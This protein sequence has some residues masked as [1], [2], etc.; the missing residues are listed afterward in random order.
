MWKYHTYA[1]ALWYV[2]NELLHFSFARLY[3]VSWGPDDL[4][5][6]PPMHL[7]GN[8]RGTRLRWSTADTLQIRLDPDSEWLHRTIYKDRH[9]HC[10]TPVRHSKTTKRGGDWTIKMLD[11]D[12][13]KITC[14]I[15]QL[16]VFCEQT[17]EGL[18]IPPT[19]CI[20]N[21]HYPYIHNLRENVNSISQTT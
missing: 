2:E 21:C 6:G 20:T 12:L 7:S 10:S 15:R 19:F 18:L 5:K 8:P 11:G 16:Q 13:P 9:F 3:K 17:K 4:K 1:D 14:S